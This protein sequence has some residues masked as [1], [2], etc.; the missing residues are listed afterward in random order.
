MLNISC[1]KYLL[2]FALIIA[3]TCQLVFWYFTK[4]IKPDMIIV[5]KAPK[6]ST[7]NLL[8]L[9]DKQFF[10]RYL[11]FKVQNAGDSWGRF[12]ALKDYNYK[13][14]IK[15]FYI[16][17]NLDGISNYPPS[18]AGY[19][20]GQTQNTA[21]TIYIIEYL[22]EHAKTDIREKW[23]WLAQA[24]YLAN[25][26]L[27]DKKL[28]LEIAYELTKVP[29]DVKM[30]MWVRQMPAF[31]HEQL[32]ENEAAKKIIVNILKNYDDLSEGEKNFM[33]YFIIERL[34]DKKFRAEIIEEMRK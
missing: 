3:I 4:H 26:R 33:E 1:K 5:P 22:R 13:E 21:D 17:N 31:I 25:H 30:P 23:W 34:K 8:S 11:G 6:Q 28:A 10:F 12:T 24:V 7:V 16:L 29:L 14:L 27:K 19:Y 9:G 32:G 2:H 15:W 20:Y 18:M